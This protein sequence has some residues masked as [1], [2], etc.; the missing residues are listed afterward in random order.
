MQRRKKH[1]KKQ[2]KPACAIPFCPLPTA[3][4]HCC[5]HKHLM[6]NLNGDLLAAAEQK[7]EICVAIIEDEI[8]GLLCSGSW[9]DSRKHNRLFSNYLQRAA[10]G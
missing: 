9:P 2:I 5:Y 10:R 4:G 8:S 1:R 7:N 6:R 3:A